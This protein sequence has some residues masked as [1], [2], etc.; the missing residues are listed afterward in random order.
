MALNNRLDTAQARITIENGMF[1]NMKRSRFKLIALFLT[2]QF[3]LMM[4]VAAWGR[5]EAGWPEW[6]CFLGAYFI[7]IVG[8]IVILYRAPMF[9]SMDSSLKMIC[10]GV[11]SFSMTLAGTVLITVLWVA[12]SLLTGMPV[13]I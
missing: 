9:G 6:S 10:L 8:Y 4:G 11:M 5:K 3:I 1:E 12:L 7:P 13:R 2:V